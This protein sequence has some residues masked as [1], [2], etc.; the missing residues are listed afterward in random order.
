M[1]VNDQVKVGGVDVSR[2][3]FAAL[4]GLEDLVRKWS[5]AINLVSKATMSDLWDRHIAD[6]AQ[7]FLLCP[8]DARAWV[9]LGSGGGFPGL[10]L[11]AIARE[12]HPGLKFTLVEADQRKATFLRQAARSLG[13]TVVVLDQRIESLAPLQA[14]VISARALA[15]LSDLLGFAAVH[16]RAGGT[17]IFPK[18]ARHAE[19]LTEAR[20]R[21]TFDIETRPS[22]SDR[23]S[24]VLVIRN[25][26]RANQD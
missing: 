1:M 14:D 4:K 2:E 12:Q 26:H 5:P 18:G 19:E 25:I 9:D 10:V 8:P 16:L 20:N 17:A 11:A 23:D 6:S 22:Q 15:P 21:W 24:A 13:L 7:L 3:T